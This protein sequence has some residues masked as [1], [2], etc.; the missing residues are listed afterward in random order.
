M[1]EKIA[2]LGFSTIF[3][4]VVLGIFCAKNIIAGLSESENSLTKAI[5]D[6]KNYCEDYLINCKGKEVIRIT[7][8]G[9]AV[10]F[11]ENWEDPRNEKDKEIACN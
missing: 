9:A 2:I 5:C 8:T 6:D 1:K 10:Q 3:V 11:S 4:L 7:P